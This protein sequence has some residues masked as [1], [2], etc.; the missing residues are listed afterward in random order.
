MSKKK[1]EVNA[2]SFIK[3][4]WNYYLEIE[5]QLY[6]IRRYIDLSSKNNNTF[7]MELLKL[8][9]SICS[10]LDVVAK[11]IDSHIY[12]DFDGG[13]MNKWDYYLQQA[14]P[15]LSDLIVL[16]NDDYEIQPWKC[17]KHIKKE[18]EYTDNG[19]KKT[20]ISYNLDEKCKTPQWWNAYNK[21]KHERT[22]PYNNNSI[23]YHRANLK[24]VVCALSALFIVESLFKDYLFN[25]EK[26]RIEYTDSKFFSFVTENL[27]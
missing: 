5:Q 25:E 24:N 26:V 8:L 4:Y 1:P 19:K 9:H 7:S 27:P 12:S 20:K 3:S 21:S 18:T 14:F 6:E 2:A 11:V 13:N 15:H 10:E 16:F 22:S 23:N 17:C